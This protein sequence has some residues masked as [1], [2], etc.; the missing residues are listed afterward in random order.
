MSAT[1]TKPRRSLWLWPVILLWKGVTRLSNRIGIIGSLT[2]G[3]ALMFLGFMLISSIV[4]VVVG[5]PVFVFGGFLF[6]A[7]RVL[8]R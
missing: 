4:G 1:A 8:A 5:V 6:C 3:I 7:R 2:L